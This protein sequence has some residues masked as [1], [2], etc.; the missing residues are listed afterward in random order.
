[1]S[2][3]P[4]PR[5][6]PGSNA[7]GLFQIGVSPI[8]SIPSFDPWLTIVSQYAN[9][10]ILTTLITDFNQ[11]LDPTLLTDN[12]YDQIYNVDTAVGYG[13]DLWGRRVGVSRTL[14][15]TTALFFGFEQQ[16]PTVDTFGPGGTSPFYSG[17]PATDNFQL[18]DA[19]FRTLIFAKML[20]NISDGSTASI[21]RL[22]MNLF[23]ERGNVYVVDGGDMTMQYVFLFT[24]TPVEA[25]IVASSGVLPKPVG[26]SATVVQL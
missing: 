18:T 21:N 8:G 26:V 20:T 19:A 9:S 7:I 11:Y 6:I 2:G 24:L 4:T 13:L 1:V 14:T 22:L 16:S 15:I 25:A 12:F 5:P 10:D 3:P 23:P 17:V